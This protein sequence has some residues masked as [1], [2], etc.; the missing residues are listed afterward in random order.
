[1]ASAT[2]ETDIA[3]RFAEAFE[4]SFANVDKLSVQDVHTAITVCEFIHTLFKTARTSIESELPLRVDASDFA[5]KYE[6]LTDTLNTVR[7]AIKRVLAK[8]RLRRTFAGR[9]ELISRYE[10]LDTYLESLR[11]FLQQAIVKAKPPAQSDER[12]QVPE[13]KSAKSNGSI[14]RLPGAKQ[15]RLH[16]LM[17]KNNLGQLDKGERKELQA[18]VREVEDL[19]IENAQR[20]AGQA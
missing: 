11:Q 20:V 14:R 12:G 10:A 3:G 8:A 13:T 9:K 17:E 7:G 4:H 2:L 16:A 15:R 6:H 18:L 5:A 19:T 1:M